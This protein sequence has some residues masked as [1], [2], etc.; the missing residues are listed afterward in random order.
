MNGRAEHKEECVAVLDEIFASR[1]FDEWRAD[2]QDEQFPW[3]P[4][5]RLTE[6]I[7]D[8]QV[9]ASGYIGEVGVDGGDP[10]RMPTGAVQF[11]ER[12]ATLRR[13]PEL[14]QDTELVLLELGLGWEEI[15]R[16][17]DARK[18]G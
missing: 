13:G 11:D 12:P 14:G 7:Q 3:A 18:I 15:G 4:F 5:Q 16:L 9:V 8:R 6:I 10:F 1:T 17:R 2:L